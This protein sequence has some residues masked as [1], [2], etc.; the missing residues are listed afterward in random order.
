MN[1]IIGYFIMLV[2]FFNECFC[3]DNSLSAKDSIQSNNSFCWAYSDSLVLSN[4]KLLNV[5]KEYDSL[6]HKDSNYV[7]ILVISQNKIN[8]VHYL[9]SYFVSKRQLL[10]YIPSGYF[11]INNQ[12]ILLYAGIEEI[13]KINEKYK[14]SLLKLT[15]NLLFDDIGTDNSIIA[16]PPVWQIKMIDDSISIK[17]GFYSNVLINFKLKSKTKFIPPKVDYE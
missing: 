15:T 4:N 6:Y 8:D 10:D 7:I 1:N 3:N 5:I 14:D 2:L 9:I 11:F 13:F 16:H 17:K 12:L